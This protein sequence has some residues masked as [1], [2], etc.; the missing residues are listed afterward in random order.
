MACVTSYTY[1]HYT[2]QYRYVCCYDKVG[3]Q[4]YTEETGRRC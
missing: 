1:C 2:T 4:C 3:Q